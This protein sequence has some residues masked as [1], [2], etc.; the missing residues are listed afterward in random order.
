MKFTIFASGSEG[1][2]ILVEEAGRGFLIDAGISRRRIVNQF[3]LRGVDAHSIDGVFLTHEHFD[4][5]QGLKTLCKYENYPVY[6][7]E[8]TIDRVQ[9]FV[10]DGD[11]RSIFLETRLNGFTVKSI[12]LPHD[13]A[14][15]KGFIIEGTSSRLMVVTDL[16]FVTE[17]IL[18]EISTCD[19]VVFESNHDV[20]ML[21][22]GPY[23]DQL[24]ERILSRWGHLSNAQ[25]AAALNNG[26]WRGLKLVVLAHL[27]R[28]NNRLELACREASKALDASTKLAA[29]DRR[30]VTGPFEI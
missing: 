2:C 16:G 7:S 3:K 25:C 12:P 21:Q 28:E 11:Y 9:R 15:P 26:K 24:K 14:E 6:A 10:P 22:N 30:E 4:H 27:S 19:A 18:R 5:T 13:A 20:E 23:S 8:G 17:R 29:A 1:N